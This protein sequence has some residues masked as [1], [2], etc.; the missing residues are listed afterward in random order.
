VGTH[1]YQRQRKGIKADFIEEIMLELN[2][3]LN[4]VER[5][6]ERAE[7]ITFIR[8]LDLSEDWISRWKQEAVFSKICGKR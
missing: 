7:K 3:D 2:H 8:R 5:L 6:E 4:I 1:F